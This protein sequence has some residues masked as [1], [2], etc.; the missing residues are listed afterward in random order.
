MVA[1]SEKPVNFYDWKSFLARFFIPLKNI[2]KYQHFIIDAGKP[3]L[4]LCKTSENSTVETHCLL[5][6]ADLLPSMSSQSCPTR[7]KGP[8]ISI[9][10]QWYLYEEIGQF[11]KSDL[12]RQATCPKPKSKKQKQSV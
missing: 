11:F 5:K 3:G 8:G 10:R 4:V 7:I 1:D 6:S 2:S 12:K 9:D